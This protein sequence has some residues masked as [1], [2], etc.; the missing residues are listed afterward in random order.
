MDFGLWCHLQWFINYNYVSKSSPSICSGFVW[1]IQWSSWSR[2]LISVKLN[3]E[4]QDSLFQDTWQPCSH[5]FFMCENPLH[6]SLLT[7]GLQVDTA[8]CFLASPSSHGSASGKHRLYL[9]DHPL[10]CEHSYKMGN[11]VYVQAT[12]YPI[13]LFIICF[14]YLKGRVTKRGRGR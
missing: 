14:I 9:S 13:F 8:S 2:S 4:K 3:T 6:L 11:N 5:F 1:K 12:D 7:C 10:S